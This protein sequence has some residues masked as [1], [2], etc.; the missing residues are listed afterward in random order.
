MPSTARPVRVGHLLIV[1]DDIQQARLFEH[2]LNDLG[3]GPTCHHALSSSTALAFLRRSPPHEKAPRPDLIILDLNMPGTDGCETLKTIKSDPEFSCI[4]V[5]MFS[6]SSD[7][8]DIGRCYRANANAY[9]RKP[10]DLDTS[11]L[12]VRHIESFW[13]HTA[14]LLR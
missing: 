5:I 2:L 3:P 6:A 11:F 14:T 12:F 1:D 8:E 4:P 13:F 9:L 7:A 10:M